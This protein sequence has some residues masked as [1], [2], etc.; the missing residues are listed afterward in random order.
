MLKNSSIKTLN[1]AS[2]LV[3]AAVLSGII[4]G[5][6]MI[7]DEEK[8]E[9]LHTHHT[10][11]PRSTILELTPQAKS[12]PISTY[13]DH[14]LSYPAPPQFHPYN[15]EEFLETP[16]PFSLLKPHTQRNA[17]LAGLNTLYTK[18]FVGHRETIAVIERPNVEK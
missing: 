17:Q 8:K 14:E 4:P 13:N 15:P 7:T 1:F 5:L 9:G 6:A 3:I 2:S 18:N 12:L 16:A 11:P 10:Y